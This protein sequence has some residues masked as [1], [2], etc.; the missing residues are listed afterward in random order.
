MGSLENN[1]PN[2]EWLAAYLDG[3]LDSEARKK[4]EDWLKQDPAARADL[5]GQYHLMI[6]W[7][8]TAPP[9]PAPEAWSALLSKLEKTPPQTSKPWWQSPGWVASILT[10]TAA[11]FW[12]TLILTGAQN[13]ISDKDDIQEMVPFA[14]ATA[15]E[16]EVLSVE[17]A[18]HP[19]L[20]VGEMPFRGPLELLQP[21]EMTVTSIPPDPRDITIRQGPDTPM[22]WANLSQK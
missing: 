2:P 4:V 1:R 22:F 6:Q 3:E 5:E 18:D 17:G 20:A 10:M 11:A 7:E 12:L 19:A 16:I 8:D 14:V 13:E 9:Q 21:G 15:D